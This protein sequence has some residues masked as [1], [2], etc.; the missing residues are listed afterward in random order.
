[1]LFPWFHAGHLVLL[2]PASWHLRSIPYPPS[3]SRPLSPPVTVASSSIPDSVDYFACRLLCIAKGKDR[4]FY[5]GFPKTLTI[6]P[7]CSPLSIPTPS[8]RNLKL[9]SNP[10]L[11]RLL[12]V[13]LLIHCLPHLAQPEYICIQGTYSCCLESEL[14]PH[15]SLYYVLYYHSF[16]RGHDSICMVT[17]LLTLVE[18]VSFTPQGTKQSFG[19][20]KLIHSPNGGLKE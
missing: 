14:N 10:G 4:F 7:F 11:Y 3:M 16:T 5:Q 18:V 6:Q 13:F 19:A 17:Y 1:M 9:F 8:S 2:M 15:Y 20:C 12:C